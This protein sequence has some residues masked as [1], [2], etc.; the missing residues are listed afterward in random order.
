M[1]QQKTPIKNSNRNFNENKPKQ[2]L[3]KKLI[4][5]KHNEQKNQQDKKFQIPAQSITHTNND[6][7]TKGAEP[8]HNK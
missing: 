1:S 8:K 7:H 2:Q 4:N 3:T 6:M 5:A